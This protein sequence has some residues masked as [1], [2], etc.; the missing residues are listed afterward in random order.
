M[1]S[2]NLC[3]DTAPLE[4]VF[5][6]Y[7]YGVLDDV[8]TKLASLDGVLAEAVKKSLALLALQ[9]RKNDVLKFCL[10]EGGFRFERAFWDEANRV[11][12]KKDLETFNILEQS[13]FRRCHP[14]GI[15][16]PPGVEASFD[17]GGR[18]PVD[19]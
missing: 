5:K 9:E 12:G 1:T 13:E 6:A 14:R 15:G 18:F 3:T 19:W 4:A 16:A 7:R 11:R 8:K 17:I 10:D 2:K